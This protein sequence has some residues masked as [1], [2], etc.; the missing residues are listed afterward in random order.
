M[1]KILRKLAVINDAATDEVARL[2]NVTDGV[3]GAATFGIGNEFDRLSIEDSQSVHSRIQRNLDLRTLVGTATEETNLDSY[4]TNI[5][6]VYVSALCP[7]GFVLIGD[8][9]TGEGLTLFNKKT[10]YGDNEVWEAV[11]TKTVQPGFDPSTGL[12]E[13]GFWVGQNGLGGY[14]WG[15]ADGDGVADGWTATGFSSTSFT[16]GVQTLVTDDTA[17]TFSRQIYFPFE[18]VEL[19]ASIDVDAVGANNATFNIEIEFIDASGS[20]ISSSST[21]ISSTGRSSVTATTPADTVIVNTVINLQATA[22]NTSS[23]EVSDPAL[24][25]GTSTTYTKT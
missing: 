1:I 22:G 15:D 10:Q 25:T 8:K 7:D 11:A 3:D 4:V 12:F 13:S 6:K 20:V 14:V 19:T 9:E 18:S 2:S 16:S 23:N 17:D 24:R 5:T 21:A